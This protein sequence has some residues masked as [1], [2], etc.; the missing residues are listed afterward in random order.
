[1]QSRP[2]NLGSFLEGIGML[3]AIITMFHLWE[4][5]RHEGR[6][7]SPSSRQRRQSAEGRQA[8]LSLPFGLGR[9]Q[10]RLRP[11]LRL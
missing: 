11:D 7:G 9:E 8:Q 3:L 10:R 5:R 6:K 2:D 4:A 1:M